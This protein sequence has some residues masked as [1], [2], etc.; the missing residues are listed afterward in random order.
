MLISTPTHQPHSEGRT[1]PIVPPA[2]FNPPSAVTPPY[3][4]SLWL[5]LPALSWAELVGP[6]PEMGGDTLSWQIS[7]G[8]SS[9]HSPSPTHGTGRERKQCPLWPP[10]VAREEIPSREWHLIQP[11]LLLMNDSPHPLLTHSLASR[12]LNWHTHSL[13]LDD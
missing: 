4:C 10:Q 13:M 8:P 1:L 2:R 7:A 3:L 11:Q 6:A 12:K 5:P 9:L